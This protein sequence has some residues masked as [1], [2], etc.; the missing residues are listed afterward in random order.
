MN[1][2]V[3]QQRADETVELAARRGQ[4]KWHVNIDFENVSERPQ[5][6]HIEQ[7]QHPHDNDIMAI[8]NEK[9]QQVFYC[10]LE[11]PNG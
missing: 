10:H 5:V 11:M 3:V 6:K 1:Y 8:P 4:R 2:V 7:T 9:L